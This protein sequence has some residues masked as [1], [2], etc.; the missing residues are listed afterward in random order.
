MQA[1]YFDDAPTRA[2]LLNFIT[3][4]LRLVLCEAGTGRPTS[5]DELAS[6]LA[7]LDTRAVASCLRTEPESTAAALTGAIRR[8][9]A[10]LDPGEAI[11]DI[12]ADSYGR[13]SFADRER[14]RLLTADLRRL[15]QDNDGTVLDRDLIAAGYSMGEQRRFVPLAQEVLARLDGRTVWRDASETQTAGER[16]RAI[17]AR[18]ADRRAAS[19]TAAAGR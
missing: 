17:G 2:A 10:E 15:A 6:W 19:L 8:R 1:T 4:Q 18:V 11:G 16:L 12:I 5:R 7:P 3:T 14:L 13:L 9:A